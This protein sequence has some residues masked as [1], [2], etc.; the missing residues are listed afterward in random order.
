MLGA[1]PRILQAKPAALR[2]G[3]MLPASGTYAPLGAAILQGMRLALQE[4]GGQWAGRSVEF[5]TV[6]DESNPSKAPEHANRLIARDKV[7]LLIGSVHSGVAL[8]MAKVARESGH[9]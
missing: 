1:A 7:D 3:V 6:D 4:S 2:I 5:L 9:L 8:G